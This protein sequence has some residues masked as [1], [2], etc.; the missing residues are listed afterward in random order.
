MFSFWTLILILATG[1][2]VNVFT[3][4]SWTENISDG[5]GA[6]TAFWVLSLIIL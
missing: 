2:V 3:P 6:I 4:D 1:T 5:L